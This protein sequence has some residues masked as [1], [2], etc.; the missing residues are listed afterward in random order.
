MAQLLVLEDDPLVLQVLTASL[1]RAGHHVLTSTRLSTALDLAVRTPPDLLICD[2]FLP[3]GQGAAVIDAFR[4]GLPDIP[5]IA[6]SGGGPFNELDSLPRARA[7]GATHS[8]RKPFPMKKL[9]DLVDHC[10]CGFDDAPV[11]D[12]PIKH[13][14]MPRLAHR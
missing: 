5:I 9:T 4:R 7:S 13:G 11:D 3:D 1:R 6:I 8:L 14:A 2:L 10:L 12:T